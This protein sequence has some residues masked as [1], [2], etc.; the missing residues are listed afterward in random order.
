MFNPF[1]YRSAGFLICHRAD[2]AA[3]W[4]LGVVVGDGVAAG[5]GVTLKV[6]I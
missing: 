5:G 3:Y 2:Q 1:C 6:S 4:L